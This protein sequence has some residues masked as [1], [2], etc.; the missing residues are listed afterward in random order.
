MNKKTA[1]KVRNDRT[2]NIPASKLLPD[3][4]NWKTH[5]AD[6]RS[7]LTSIFAEVGFVGHVIVRPAPRKR[8][9]YYIVDGHERVETIRAEHGPDVD[10]PCVVV[11]LSDAEAR[12]IL[13]SY[14]AVGMMGGV[15]LDK[16][17]ELT[18]KVQ[19]DAEAADD[20]IADALSIAD[21]LAGGDENGDGSSDESV[22]EIEAET[23]R[24]GWRVI[25]H[26][27][28][29]GEQMQLIEEFKQRGYTAREAD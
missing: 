26:C 25:V 9:M 2:A 21:Q 10:V 28:S 8:G 15:D 24:E 7:L 16:F 12:K 3:P 14:N 17:K 4:L 18:A 19:F 20:L 11:K 27:D 5:T 13:K 6:Q 1:L 29:P 23:S 22:G